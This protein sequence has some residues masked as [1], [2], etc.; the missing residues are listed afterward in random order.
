VAEQIHSGL[1]IKIYHSVEEIGA[2]AWDDLSEEKPYQSARWYEYGERVMEGSK[3]VYLVVFHNNQPV[4]RGTFWV[5]KEEPLP[6]SV[7]LNKRLQPFFRRWPLFICRSPL[8][9]SSGLILP[10]TRFREDALRLI[11]Q[12]AKHQANH[13]HCAFIIYDFLSSKEVK[14]SGWPNG[15]LHT[16]GGEP[17]TI[18]K[19]EWASFEEYMD[20]RDPRNRRRVAYNKRKAVE[21]GITVSR[22]DSAMHI[23]EAVRLVEQ[24]EE[25]YGSPRNP[26]TRKM[27]E[28]MGMVESTF[29]EARIGTELVGCELILYDNK[30]Q[31]PTALGHAGSASY[32][33]LEMLYANLCDAIDKRC[34]LMR[35][36][37]GSYDI[38]RHLGFELEDMNYVVVA[39]TSLI[40]SLLAR[41]ASAF[42]R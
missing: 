19:V 14:N 23:N 1:N 25:K 12:E 6:V 15:C 31:L 11:A 41:L 21:M 39:G 27:L 4:A 5:V 10:E 18:M 24:V 34:K 38:K 26:W 2:A 28:N 33:Y 17:G 3:P 36:G 8:S 13:Y 42:M 16:T 22:H 35:W 20:T 29:L 32:D 37:S 7:S 9:N 40:S 30:A